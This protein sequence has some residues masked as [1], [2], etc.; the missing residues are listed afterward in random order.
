MILWF[1]IVRPFARFIRRR[2]RR[3]HRRRP[4]KSIAIFYFFIRFVRFGV[5]TRFDSIRIHLLQVVRA[6]PHNANLDS[7]K[8][9]L[10]RTAL[11]RTDACSVRRVRV[12]CSVGTV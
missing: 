2:R 6:S 8:T 12:G 9:A 10:S 7:N 3:C 11:A 5:P 1:G 4:T